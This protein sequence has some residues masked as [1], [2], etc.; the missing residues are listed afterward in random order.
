MTYENINNLIKD[1]GFYRQKTFSDKLPIE[2]QDGPIPP[3][4]GIFIED[5]LA[6]YSLCEKYGGR[7]DLNVEYP[8][9]VQI[10]MNCLYSIS[11]FIFNITLILINTS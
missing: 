4:N 5:L 11:V 2:Y 10:N 7:N 8:C 1:L 9:G 3:E 6:G